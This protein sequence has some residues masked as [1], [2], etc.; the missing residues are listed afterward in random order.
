MSLA[1][2]KAICI[3]YRFNN[4]KL[5][6][7]ADKQKERK[8]MSRMLE[9]LKMKLEEWSKFFK[10]KKASRLNKRENPFSKKVNR[11][12]Q[13]VTSENDMSIKDDRRLMSIRDKTEKPNLMKEIDEQEENYTLN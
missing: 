3:T 11:V 4:Y 13:G 9:K 10:A 2:E 5:R 12:S 8:A 1:D 7:V 6:K